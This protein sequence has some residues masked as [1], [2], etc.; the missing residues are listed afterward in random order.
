MAT[1]QLTVDEEIHAAL[2]REKERRK[3]MT[4]QGITDEVIR[5]GLRVKRIEFEDAVGSEEG[6][7]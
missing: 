4:L 3:G 2:M 1:K 6:A 5:A 7:R